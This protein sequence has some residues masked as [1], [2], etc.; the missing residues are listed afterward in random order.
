MNFNKKII[1]G[2]Y[3]IKSTAFSDEKG[4]EYAIK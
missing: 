1:Y 3:I 2:N 4:D